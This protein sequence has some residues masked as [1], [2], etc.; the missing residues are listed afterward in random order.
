MPALLADEASLAL[1]VHYVRHRDAV[2]RWSLQFCAGRAALAQDI[3]QDVFVRLF[4]N[5]HRLSDHDDL[6]GWLYRVT[7]NLCRTRIKREQS[8]LH[9]FSRKLVVE[10]PD[11]SGPDG[12]AKDEA[13]A[14]L[15]TLAELPAKERIA[16][17]MK[18]FDGKS[19]REIAQ[20]MGV[21]EPLVSRWIGRAWQQIRA[22]GWEVD[23]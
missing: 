4:E 2:Y 9:R 14:A 8:W 20:T 21:S 6:G 17:C 16:F 11:S 3:T 5:L 1:E 22:A 13:Q 18:L 19:Q 12:Q 23:T 7:V 10:Q 15:A